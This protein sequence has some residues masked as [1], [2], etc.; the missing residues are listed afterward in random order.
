MIAAVPR[1]PAVRMFLSEDSMEKREIGIEKSMMRILTTP[2]G[3]RVML[4]QYGSKLFELV[5]KSVD[6]IWVLDAIAYTHEA[7]EKNEKRV[8]L[9]KVRVNTDNETVINIEYEALGETKTMSL[10]MGE[11]RDAAA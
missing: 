5:D 9:K 8:K 2:L 11:V 1:Q 10:S 3:A 4:P 6:D 7:I